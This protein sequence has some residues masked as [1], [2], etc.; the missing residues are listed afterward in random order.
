MFRLHRG[1]SDLELVEWVDLDKRVAIVP[2]QVNFTTDV[3]EAAKIGRRELRQG[4]LVILSLA[5]EEGLF[6]TLVPPN[7]GQSGWYETAVPVDLDFVPN[8]ILSDWE[9]IREYGPKLD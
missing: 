3:E 6:R 7:P 2:P 1:M 4:A 8:N 5:Y 9:A